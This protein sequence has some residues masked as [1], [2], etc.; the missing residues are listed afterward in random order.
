MKLEAAGCIRIV[1]ENIQ[2][3]T[4]EKDSVGYYVESLPLGRI[5]SYFYMKHESMKQF[6]ENLINHETIPELTKLLTDASEFSE[7]PV[8][9]CEDELNTKLAQ[10]CP[11]PVRDLS[12][13]SPHTKAFLLLQARFFSLRLPITDYITDTKT[14]MSNAMRVNSCL[15]QVAAQEGLLLQSIRLMRL[16]QLLT[17]AIAPNTNELLQLPHI[18]GPMAHSMLQRLRISSLAELVFVPHSKVQK[19]LNAIG[20]ERLNKDQKDKFM[21][22]LSSIPKMDISWHVAGSPNNEII[23][24][25]NSGYSSQH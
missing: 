12:Y 3:L 17:Q 20:G 1:E 9:H 24:I 8:R 5:G 15:I 10:S 4:S 22:V 23:A 2:E 11:W 6:A 25:I 7:L 19:T 21:R 14:V 18:S 16:S 13:E